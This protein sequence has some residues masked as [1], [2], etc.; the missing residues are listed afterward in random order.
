[1]KICKWSKCGKEFEPTKF[2]QDYCRPECRH[3]HNN[4][5]KTS[6][7]HLTA[8][9]EFKLSRIAK[10]QQKT[11]AQLLNEA[12]DIAF[13]EPGLPITEAEIDGINQV[14]PTGKS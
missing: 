8:R 1:M 5:L 6:G 12:V 10:F 3:A 7:Y 9:N 2:N 11:N 14:I 13:P 4:Y